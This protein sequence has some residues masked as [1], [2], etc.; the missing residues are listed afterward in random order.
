MAL[1][2]EI[3]F[4]RLKKADHPAMP[5]VWITDQQFKLFLQRKLSNFPGFTVLAADGWWKGE[6]EPSSVV[7]LYGSDNEAFK[8]EVGAIARAYAEEHNQEAVAFSFDEVPFYLASADAITDA[9]PDH[10]LPED[11]G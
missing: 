9:F 5:G 3:F 7:V 1:R 10:A 8:R 6:K 4:G 2:A 11:L